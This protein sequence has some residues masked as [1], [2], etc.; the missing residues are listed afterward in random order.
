MYKV[1]L[2]L[3]L[4]VISCKVDKGNAFAQEEDFGWIVGGWSRVNNKEG[5]RTYEYWDKFSEYNYKGLGCTLRGKDTIFKEV[6]VL[7]KK[8]SNWELVVLGV[9]DEPTVFKVTKI[10][11]ASFECVNELND[12][13]KKIAY[14]K[15]GK[16]LKAVISDEDK[17]I[18][19]KFTPL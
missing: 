3:C 14:Q 5:I 12:F 8:R 17:D 10:D 11:S 13:P 15:I 9:N 2:F 6:L 7:Q 1:L 19:F 18:V 4:I 16:Q